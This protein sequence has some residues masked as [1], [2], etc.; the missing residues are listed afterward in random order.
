MKPHVHV[1]RCCFEIFECQNP[2]C[3]I[4]RD[5]YAVCPDC[6]QKSNFAEATPHWRGIAS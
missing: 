4:P 5:G 3:T 6:Y 2:A 1:C